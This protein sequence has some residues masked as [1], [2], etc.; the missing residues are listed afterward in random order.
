LRIVDQRSHL[1]LLVT[2]VGIPGLG[3]R[4]LADAARKAMP[5]LRILFITGYAGAALDAIPLTDGMEILRKP[6]S[7]DEVAACVAAILTG[8]TGL[9]ERGQLSA[10]RDV[11]AFNGKKGEP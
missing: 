6:F 4:Q 3:G 2:D 10:G 8:S 11:P 5:A 1:D 7:L 9:T